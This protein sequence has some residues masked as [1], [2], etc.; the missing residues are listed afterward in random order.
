MCTCANGTQAANS[1]LSLKKLQSILLFVVV[2]DE[3]KQE[4]EE[5]LSGR[6]RSIASCNHKTVVLVFV[7]N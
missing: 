5:K 2:V 4:R 3:T 7:N 6:G 1:S